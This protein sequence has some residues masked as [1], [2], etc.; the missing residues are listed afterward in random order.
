MLNEQWSIKQHILRTVA[1][2]NSIAFRKKTKQ[3]R[4]TLE[5]Y[6]KLQRK[7]GKRHT[8]DVPSCTSEGKTHY[9]KPLLTVL[10]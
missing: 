8:A 2:K 9:Q 1:S 7:R 4:E 5:A 10:L 6:V 3:F